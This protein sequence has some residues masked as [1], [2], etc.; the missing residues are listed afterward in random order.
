M[1]ESINEN[2]MSIP[3]YILKRI[4]ISIPTIII[5]SVIGFFLMRYDFTLP[6]INLPIGKQGIHISEARR[7]KNP[8][9][10]LAIYRNNPAISQQALEKEEARLG[11]DKPMWKQYMLWV[12]HAVQL[13]P[14]LGKTFNGDNV[15][16]ILFRRAGNTLI[17]NLC[18][19]ILSWLVAIPLGVY[20]ALRWRTST[21]RMMTALAAIGM[22]FP[23]F[24]LAIILGVIVVK[25]GILPF[26]GAYSENYYELGLFGKIID[27]AKFLVL[28]VF[29]MTIGSLAGLQRQMRGNLL[30]VLGAEYV[31][32]ARAKGLPENVVIYKHAVRTAINPLV[33]MMGYEFAA[34]L[35]G[36]ILIETVLNYPGLGLLTYKA[37]QQADTNLVMASLTLSAIMLVLGNLLADIILKFVDPR[38]ELS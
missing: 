16:D 35:G 29:V 4:L 26:S 10:P 17:L 22:S 25:T 18:V 24:V 11:L 31:R 5:V 28:P 15:G 19:L 8:I 21:D 20:A 3:V 6:A 27:R 14:D 32:T 36:S 1:S 12:T 2:L 34:M 7:I 37:V 38:I 33:T 9:D 13:P 23:G 30:D